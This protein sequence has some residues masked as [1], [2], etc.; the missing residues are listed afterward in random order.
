MQPITQE[1]LSEAHAGFTRA[2][3][4]PAFKEFASQLSDVL[5]DSH[6]TFWKCRTALAFLSRSRAALGYV[7]SE[8]L[9]SLQSTCYFPRLTLVE[10]DLFSLRLVIVSPRPAARVIHSMVEHQMLAVIQGSAQLQRFER[11]DRG[12]HDVFN[13]Q[14]RIFSSG[15]STL[16]AGDV[17]ELWADRECYEL[18][19]RTNAFLFQL[20]SRPLYR[21]QWVYDAATLAPKRI[22]SSHAEDMQAE[23]AILTARNLG[24]SDCVPN[25]R[26]LLDHPN[27]V[28][29][30]AAFNT[31]VALDPE[32]RE[33]YLRVAA[34]D[35]HPDVQ[36]AAL[37]PVPPSKG[38]EP[39]H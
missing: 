19:T 12:A 8:L 38:C 14:K 17:A 11:A 28:I 5:G 33:V 13:A 37:Y 31:L 23:L 20:R 22:Y 21:L 15:V 1:P 34:N 4:L 7:E 27:H 32:N 16:V 9:N 25:V 2:I 24:F 30:R 6:E 10:S 35:P 3:D 29:R 18:S 26:R 39:W 36:Q